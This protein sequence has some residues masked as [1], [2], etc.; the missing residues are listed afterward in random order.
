MRFHDTCKVVLSGNLDKTDLSGHALFKDL[1][2]ERGPEGFYTFEYFIQLEGGKLVTSER[3]S[4]FVRSDIYSMDSLNSMPDGGS[5]L[6]VP[7]PEQPIVRIRDNEGKPVQGRRVIAFSWIDPTFLESVLDFKNSPSHL[8]FLTLENF[9]SEPSDENGLAKFTNLMVTGSNDVFA[10]IHFYAEG[11][12][13][14]WSDRPFGTGFE[15]FSPQRAVL[16]Y[17][18]KL[19]PVEIEIAND[20][21]RE[22]VEGKPFDDPYILVVRNSDTLQPV[23]GRMCFANMYEGSQGRIPAGYESWFDGLPVTYLMNPLPGEYNESAHDPNFAGEIMSQIYLTD[24]NGRVKFNDLKFSTTG[25]N[26]YSR[27]QFT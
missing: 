23:A 6:N 17:S 19:D 12:T 8:K 1:K 11:V 25:S 16:P 15:Q 21:D 13:T 9:I 14:P 4:A 27:I 20:Y 22:V 18:A 10:F 26:G 2:I 5:V 3:L 7:F 24:K